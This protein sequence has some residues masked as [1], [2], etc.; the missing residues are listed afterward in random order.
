M[1]PTDVRTKQSIAALTI[2]VVI[3]LLWIVMPHPILIVA[4]CFAPLALLFVLNQTFWLVTL[5]VIFSFSVFT[6]RFLPFTALKFHCF[7][8]WRVSCA[9]FSSTAKSS[10]YGILAPFT[11]VVVHFLG[12]GYHRDCVRL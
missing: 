10:T 3:A 9:S 7:Y 11:Q 8:P 12:S 2:T 5:F 6:K 4:V 1:S